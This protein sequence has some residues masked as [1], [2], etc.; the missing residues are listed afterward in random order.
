MAIDL[1]A[2]QPSP[3]P[4]SLASVFGE[5]GPVRNFVGDNRLALMGLGAGIASGTD[6]G[7]GIGMGLRNAIPLAQMD[8]Q[9]RDDRKSRDATTAWLQSMASTDPRF[10]TLLQ[11]VEGGAVDPGAAFTAGI[12][13]MTP[14][15][16]DYGFTEVDGN[17]IRTDATSGNVEN[18]W[19]P[20]PVAPGTLTPEMITGEG[21]LRR[22]YSGL[23]G[24]FRDQTAAYQRVLD[25]SRDPSA[26]GDLALIFNYMKVLDPGSTV[27]EGEFATAQNSGSIPERVWAL[28]NNVMSGERLTPEIRADFVRR[29]G[30]LYQGAAQLQTGINDQYSGLAGQY[31]F[32]PSRVVSPVPQ[33]GVMDPN[34]D[35]PTHLGMGDMPRIQDDAGFD[36]LPSGTVFVAPDGS[37]RRKP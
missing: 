27:R 16:P 25:S 18:V 11:G 3:V 28:Y 24:D 8:R 17:L 19:S 9:R 6:F 15:G 14:T 33:I 21:A 30:Q 36:A 26:A 4:M 22:E 5:G 1:M 2:N 23:S 10:A 35:L 7:E 13:L 20:Q 37:V 32:D 12:G 29:A 34:F 31:G